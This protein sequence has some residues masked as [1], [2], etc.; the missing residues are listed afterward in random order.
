MIQHAQTFQGKVMKHSLSFLWRFWACFLLA[1][2]GFTAKYVENSVE[3]IWPKH[4]KLSNKI[5]KSYRDNV[6][7]LTL[8]LQWKKKPSVCAVDARE[9]NRVAFS[10]LMLFKHLLDNGCPEIPI[11]QLGAG[12]NNIHTQTAPKLSQERTSAGTLWG[13]AH[14]WGPSS[15]QKLHVPPQMTDT[16]SVLLSFSL[17]TPQTE[18]HDSIFRALN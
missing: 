8:Y 12:D 4:Q 1:V 15:V 13:S 18:S 6:P 10:A 3:K 9:M 14:F 7:D 16:H 2:I 17:F 5:N 11:Y